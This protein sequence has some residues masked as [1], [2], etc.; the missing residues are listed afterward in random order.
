M[1]VAVPTGIERVKEAV[2]AS[3]AAKQKVAD[4]QAALAMAQAEYRVAEAN[5]ASLIASGA[6][7]ADCASLD[8][9]HTNGH[10]TNGAVYAPARAKP[11]YALTDK[12]VPKVWRIAFMLLADPILDYAYTSS[13]LWGPCSKATAKNRVGAH[14][15]H[16]KKL[17]VIKSLG[18]NKY[19]VD[20]AKLAEQSG[21]PTE[22]PS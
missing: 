2:Y 8:H 15:T 3:D 17:G 22:A 6:C 10:V 20:K 4:A 13:T 12:A 11:L 21:L 9:E 14:L 19:A 16:L 1:K 5:L 18:A 7:A